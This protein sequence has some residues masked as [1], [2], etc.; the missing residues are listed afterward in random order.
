MFSRLTAA[1]LKH[2]HCQ[3]TLTSRFSGISPVHF[4]VKLSSNKTRRFFSTSPTATAPKTS[5]TRWQRFAQVVCFIRI[6]VV[7]ISV[8][9][10]GYQQG[11]MDCTKELGQRETAIKQ[12]RLKKAVEN[13]TS[14]V[15]R[16]VLRELMPILKLAARK[17]TVGAV[18]CSNFPS[19]MMYA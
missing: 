15:A 6:P 4:R 11:V 14:Q 8:Y 2:P 16:V 12:L 13:P 19:H 10:L 18:S 5:K 3:L 9:T 7:V 1:T 17:N